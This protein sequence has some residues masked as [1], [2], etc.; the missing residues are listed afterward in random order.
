MRKAGADWQMILYGGAVHGFTNPDA[1]SDKT[2]GVAYDEE[3]DRRSWQAMRN[4]LYRML[5]QPPMKKRR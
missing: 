5:L 1:G 2:K 4:F 3:A